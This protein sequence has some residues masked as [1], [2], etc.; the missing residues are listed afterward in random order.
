MV[1]TSNPKQMAIDS[2]KNFLETEKSDSQ[3]VR[4]DWWRFATTFLGI[5]FVG[6]IASA[7]SLLVT[8]PS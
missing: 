6:L 4:D 5:W 1:T 8:L 3:V 2:I 7:V